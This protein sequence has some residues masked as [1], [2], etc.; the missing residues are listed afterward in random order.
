MQMEMGYGEEEAG[1]SSA[2]LK[3]AQCEN[4][5]DAIASCCASE[6]DGEEKDE[7]EEERKDGSDHEEIDGEDEEHEFVPGPLLS[8]KDQLEKD[9]DDE[10]LRKWKAKLLGCVEATDGNR[11]TEVI[12]HSI[13]IISDGCTETMTPLP[14]TENQNSMLFSLKE[15][16][17]YFLKLKFSVRHN[18]VC[19]LNYVNTVWKKGV[20]VDQSRGMLGTFAPQQEPYEHLLEEETTPSGALARGLYT[21][22]LKFEDDDKRNHLELNYCFEIRRT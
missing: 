15:G 18:L 21:A 8:L 10:S 14:I 5:N 6:V 1:S 19:G 11:E 4:G 2:P 9:K 3:V 12:F 22:K 16:S 7:E 17:Q 13:G 20:R